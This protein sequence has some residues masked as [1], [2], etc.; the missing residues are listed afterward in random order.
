MTT[1]HEPARDLESG[2]PRAEG[3]PRVLIVDDE[4]AVRGVL[5]RALARA[6]YVIEEATDGEEA[7]AILSTTGADIVLSDL[8]MPRMNGMELLARAKAIDDTIGFIM[9]TGVGTVENAIEA[10]RRQADDY[11]LKPFNIEEVRI[12]VE[13]ALQHRQL[14]LENRAYQREL[15]QR[16][17]EQAHKIE[18][19]LLEGLLIVASAV[20]ARDGYTGEHV[21]RVSRY[22]VAT[23]NRL[24]LDR[25]VLRA[26]WMGAILHDVG[27]VAIPDNILKKNGPLNDD[28][29]EIMRR[30]PL[31]S[32]SIV[33]RSSFLKPALPGILHHH[34]RWDGKGYPYGLSGE[35][36]SLEGR[37]ISVADAFDAITTRR[38]YRDKRS[39]E[40]AVRELRECAGTQFDQKVVEAFLAAMED[41]F[42]DVRGLWPA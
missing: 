3:V 34:E 11:L 40:E 16:V 25:D 4:A 17:E 29:R 9:L 7:L 32:A 28:E 8:L 26:L 15:E 37:I 2:S 27:K 14:L 39:R 12:S 10:L 31:I 30:H 41:G 35:S 22:A 6:D 33:E 24:G 1:L 20:E 42:E 38:P 18:R 13:R 23:G 36:I 19:L 5:R 21:G